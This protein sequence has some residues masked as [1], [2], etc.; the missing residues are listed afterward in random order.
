MDNP[1][2]DYKA[3]WSRAAA[4]MERDGV[5]ALFLM[6]PANLAYFTGD[7][8]PCALALL[9]RTQRCVVAVPACDV[10]SV[11][12]ASAATEIRAFQSEAEMFHGFRDVL[13]EL[14]LTQATIAI[15]KNFF[16]AALYDVFVAHILP[17]A[18]VVPATP[19]I[20]QLRMIKDPEEIA[21]LKAAARVAD[22]G[23]S[24]AAR[25]LR[26]GVSE[27]E[28][29]GEAELAMRKAGA[30][31]WAS[32]TYVASGWRSAMAHGPATAKIIAA[33]EV[34]QVHLAP[35]VQGYAADLC[36][37]FLIEPV[38]VDAASAL[39]AYIDAQE[40]GIA[41]AISGAVLLG[42]DGAMATS[43]EQ[44]GYAGKFLRPVFHGVGIEHEEAPIP[45]G[46]AVIHGEQKVEHVMVGMVLGIGNCGIYRETFGVR[47]E[48]TIWVS[49]SGPVALTRFPKYLTVPGSVEAR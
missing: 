11:Q 39:H 10:A 30:E 29:A 38:P 12:R 8:R 48:D 27:A 47:A 21:C 26:P 7:G 14:G 41:A 2:F 46:H 49:E 45:G 35:M 34:V 24:A 9:T 15:E 28:I 32:V 42:I 37:T 40:R 4:L 44:A 18:K 22:A 1:T 5:D 17:Q 43:L 36:R 33:G 23:M 13:Q 6:K 16:D 25:A 20:S 31:G 19:I 3:R